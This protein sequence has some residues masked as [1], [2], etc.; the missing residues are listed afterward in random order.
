MVKV[1]TQDSLFLSLEKPDAPM[2]LG[3]LIVCRLPRGAG[4]DFMQ[5]LH[6]RLGRCAV[7]REP[8]NLR[9]VESRGLARY[10][11]K[12]ADEVDLEYHLRHEALPWPGGERELGLAISRLHSVP[13]ERS[14]PLW[15][16]TLIEGLR[17]DRFALYLKIH[18]ALSDGVG[19]LDK[20]AS[21]FAASPRGLSLPPWSAPPVR[22]PKPKPTQSADADWQHFFAE[23]LAT[24]GRGGRGPHGPPLIPR[25]PSCLLNG[26]GTGRRRVAT[27]DLPLARVK[28]IAREADATVNDVVLALCSGAL[29]AYLA[30]FDR[31]PTES[32]LATVPVAMPRASGETIGSS[33]ASI[34]TALATTVADPRRRLLAI[35][36]SMRAAKEEFKVMPASLHR[37]VNSLGMQLMT[38]MPQRPNR[39]LEHASFTN[40]TVSNVPGPMQGLYFRG[41]QIEA[42]YPLSVLAGDQRLNITVL[43]Y[44]D[45]LHF[46]L[47]AC[48]DTLPSVQYIAVQLPAALR[49]L[50]AAMAGARRRRGEAGSRR[51]PTVSR[52]A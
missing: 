48:P 41:A 28:A 37:A 47:V 40:L 30:K 16:F 17:P 3:A 43:S 24:I 15:E 44:R 26:N 38:L 6:T 29:R 39:D 46:G 42:M 49:N 14:R 4:P 32:L 20:L 36:D 31:V 34:H 51:R 25:G 10:S 35:R 18:H 50:E 5:E 22:A 13:L 2:H 1:N 23:L 19:L 7:D 52:K 8:F 11:W 12:V 45:R 9:L 27:Q 21:G 33:V